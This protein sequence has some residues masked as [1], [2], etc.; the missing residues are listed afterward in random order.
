MYMADLGSND[1]VPSAYPV[2]VCCAC[3]G[4][5]KCTNSVPKVTLMGFSADF[6]K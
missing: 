2:P 4:N 3:K 1:G 5:P 6:I